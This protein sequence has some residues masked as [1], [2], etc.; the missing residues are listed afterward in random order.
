MPRSINE[1][2][3]AALAR[4]EHSILQIQRKLT[5]KGFEEA[6]I[7]AAINHLTENNLLSEERFTESYINMRK[8]RG[9][10]PIRIA[11]ELRE[12]GISDTLFCGFLDKNNPQWREV[13]RQQYVKKYA[14]SEAHEYAEKVRRAKYLQS[15]GFPLD[16][17]FKLNSIDLYDE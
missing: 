2:A 6:E 11:Q 14:D 3:V 13:M 16:W 4:R 15:R 17:V 8:R 5:Q 12:R 7:N 9:Y 10:G 1:V